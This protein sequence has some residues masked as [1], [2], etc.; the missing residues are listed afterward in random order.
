MHIAVIVL[1]EQVNAVNTKELEAE[2]LSLKA[3]V[4][5]LR[6]APHDQSIA[7]FCQR[8]GVSR[9]TFWRWRKSGL[10]PKTLTVGGRVIIPEE[11]EREWLIRH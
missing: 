1:T 9:A 10:A 7:G 5:K 4:A 8:H 6:T 3:E 2:I 11:F